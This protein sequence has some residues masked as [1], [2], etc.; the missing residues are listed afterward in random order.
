MPTRKTLVNP[1]ADR[2]D[3]VL[4]LPSEV[5]A[6]AWAVDASCIGNPGDT[7]YQCVDLA[8]GE[9][10]FRYGPFFGTNNIGEF[11]AIVHAVSLMAQRGITGKVV[12][13]DS[14]SAI[15]WVRNKKC[16]TLLAETADTAKA[17]ALLRRAETWLRTH[18]V[19]TPIIK[20]ETHRWGEIPAD[21]GRKK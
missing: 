13:S 15:A 17:F 21:F 1:P 16:K 18:S 10:V 12:Y 5:S 19:A 2:H 6:N 14:I 11:L 8:T 7:E 3:T 4:P 9:V 20:W